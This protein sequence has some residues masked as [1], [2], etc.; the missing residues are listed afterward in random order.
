MSVYVDCEHGSDPQCCVVCGPAPAHRDRP[1][2]FRARYGGD[3]R[4]GCRGVEPGDL[5]VELRA[6]GYRHATTGG[7]R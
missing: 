4:R 1:S 3:C 7:C 5:I 2:P 6:G